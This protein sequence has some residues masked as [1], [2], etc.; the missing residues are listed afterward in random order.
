MK[1]HIEKSAGDGDVSNCVTNLIHAFTDGLNVFKRLRERRKK[2]KSKAKEREAE[3]PSGAELQLSN[4]L[5]KGP[6]ELRAKY[7]RCYSEKGEG[8]SKGD[9]KSLDYTWA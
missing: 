3:T 2:S 4:S 7:E 5:R 8:F 1:D 9:G 6:V